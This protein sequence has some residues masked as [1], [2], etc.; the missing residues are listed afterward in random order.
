MLVAYGATPATF[1]S[2]Y[3]I[4]PTPSI[5]LTPRSGV[6]SGPFKAT[7]NSGDGSCSPTTAQFYWDGSPVG[8]P[9]A[10]DAKCVATLTFNKPPAKRIGSAQGHRRFCPDGCLV[11]TEAAATYTIVALRSRRQPLP[12]RRSPRRGRPSRRRQRRPP[13]T[14]SPTTASPTLSAPTGFTKPKPGADRRGPWRDEPAADT[15]TGA[16]H[17]RRHPDLLAPG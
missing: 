1:D 4:D 13:P 14:P 17:R 5:V 3:N 15:V 12:R 2:N 6:A 8:S 10:A 11:R 9:V 16:G 7:Y